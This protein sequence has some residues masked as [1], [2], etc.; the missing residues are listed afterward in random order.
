MI[1]MMM[2]VMVIFAGWCRSIVSSIPFHVFELAITASMGFHMSRQ[3]VIYG[4]ICVAQIDWGGCMTIAR[5]GGW[6]DETRIDKQRTLQV[7]I[8]QQLDVQCSVECKE[9]GSN[10]WSSWLGIFGVRM[11]KTVSFFLRS[12]TF[13]VGAVAAFKYT[14]FYGIL[15]ALHHF[16]E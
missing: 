16:I 2:V 3:R 10:I 5:R 13:R 11:Q 7:S 12:P 1:M 15:K 4:N 9:I 6:T 8:R 14:C